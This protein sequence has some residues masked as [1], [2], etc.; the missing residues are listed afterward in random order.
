MHGPADGVTDITAGTNTMPGHAGYQA[1]SG[2]DLPTGIG[3]IGNALL[4]ATTLARLTRHQPPGP[5][6]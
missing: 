4:F 3:T 2:Y 5:R 1:R 6:P